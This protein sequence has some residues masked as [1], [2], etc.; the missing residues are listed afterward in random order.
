MF[1]AEWQLNS[2]PFF[3]HTLP[4]EAFF[5]PSSDPDF[6]VTPECGELPPSGTEGTL[7]KVAYKPQIYGKTHKAKLVVQVRSISLNWPLFPTRSQ[8]LSDGNAW[9]EHENFRAMS[10]MTE[11]TFSRPFSYHAP[12][13]A[14][15]FLVSRD[16]SCLLTNDKNCNW[17]L[18][19]FCW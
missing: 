9:K 10:V 12:H 19:L 2:L 14:E 18:S 5:A 1:F 13:M 8:I 16:F 11:V 17:Q 15:C 7:I 4:F 3:R 6:T